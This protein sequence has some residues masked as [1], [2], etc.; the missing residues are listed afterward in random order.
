MSCFFI[1][2]GLLL[3]SII[4]VAGGFRNWEFSAYAM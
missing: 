4:G 3:G 1:V 2:T